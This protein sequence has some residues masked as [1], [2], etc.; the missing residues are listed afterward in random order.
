[1]LPP[2]K[3]WLTDPCLKPCM[4]DVLMSFPEVVDN[5]PAACKACKD[6]EKQRKKDCDE[7]RKR[8][9]EALKKAGCPSSVTPHKKPAGKKC[10]STKTCPQMRHNRSVSTYY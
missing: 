6:D 9:R 2:D 8:V 10:T 5:T 3:P 1:M 7:M 4:K